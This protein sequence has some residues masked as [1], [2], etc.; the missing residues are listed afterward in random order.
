MNIAEILCRHAATSPDAPAIR[1]V[2]GGLPR[3]LTFREL[4]T[5]AARAASF[6]RSQGLGPADRIL[7]LQ[8]MSAELYVALIAIFRIGAVAMFLDPSAGREHIERCCAIAPPSALLAGAKAHVLR[9]VSRALR[10]IPRKISIGTALP[11]ASSW[12]HISEHAPNPAIYS[13]EADTPALLTFTSGSTGEPKAAMRT[14]GFLLAQHQALADALRLGPGDLDLATLPIFVLANLGSGASTL[15]PDADLRRP[16]QIKSA[17]LVKQIAAHKP[18]S[19]AA[20]PAL[21]ERIADHCIATGTLLINFRKIFVGGAP[22]F[23]RVLRKLQK[24]APC[25]EIVAVYGSTEAEPIAEISAASISEADYRAMESGRGLLTGP[26]VPAIRLRVIPDQWGTSITR[27]ETA[28][29][30]A[31]SLPPGEI[32]EIVVSGV[33]VLHSYW[34]GTGDH[35]TKFR[36]GAAVWHRTGDAGYLDRSGRLWLLGRCSARV[37]D[38]RGQ[39]YPFAVECA[40]SSEVGLRRAAFVGHQ[41]RRILFLE[42]E[43]DIN[44]DDLTARLRSSLSW[45]AIDDFRLVHRIPVDARHN[46]KVN[47]TEL[48][49]MISR[50][51]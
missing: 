44:S 4:E 40:A 35:E 21:C 31:A 29:F 41:D 20:S 25:A 49:R 23:P 28:Q 37:S 10:R 43:R 15:I 5:L 33:H 9:F 39:L 46:A 22:V 50:T 14:H 26:P 42:P 48:L 13:A 8:P 19:T 36:V 11:G 6:L 32:G 16:G 45:A 1:D 38:R 27:L 7:V 51:G 17:A 24:I 18:V 30:D 3:T 34:G 2:K 12:N 47:F